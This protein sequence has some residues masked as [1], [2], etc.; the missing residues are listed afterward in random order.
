MNELQAEQIIQL[1]T[2]IRDDQRRF[3][4]LLQDPGPDAGHVHAPADGSSPAM[5]FWVCKC[6]FVHDDE[7]KD[8]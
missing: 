8:A 7:R 6:G 3:I 1:L 5:P 2:E 4:L